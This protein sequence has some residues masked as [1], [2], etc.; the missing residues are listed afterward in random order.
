M[1]PNDLEIAYKEAIS[2]GQTISCLIITNPDNPL[3][4]LLTKSDYINYLSFAKKYKLNIIIDEIYSNSIIEGEFISSLD[5]IDTYFSNNE[6]EIEF[7]KNHTF[8]I[9]GPSKDFGMNGFRAGYLYTENRDVFLQFMD[10]NVRST[11]STYLQSALMYLF[12]DKEWVLDY[13]K[14]YKIMLKQ[15]YKRVTELLDMYK[16]PYVP[17]YA[18]VF[19]CVDLRKY[20]KELTFE[21]ESRLSRHMTYNH[22]L[23]INPGES[24]YF[25]EPGF[26][27]IVYTDKKEYENIIHRLKEALDTYK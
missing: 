8:I 22:F 7:F 25:K 9:N 10:K 24:M 21:E 26:F 15:Y 14:E 19:L 17:A 27:R 6:N 18:G 1:R 2:S 4:K 20:M 23:Y 13:I 3:G 12:N 11:P 5:I 16:I